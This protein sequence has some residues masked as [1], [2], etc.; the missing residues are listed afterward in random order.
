MT[1]FS[2]A[3]DASE[4]RQQD[5]HVVRHA[6]V[7]EKGQKVRGD[8]QA[9]VEIYHFNNAEEYKATEIVTKLEKEFSRRQF[10]EFEYADVAESECKHNH[11]VGF[12]NCPFKLKGLFMSHSSEISVESL[13]N[14]NEHCHVEDTEV[15]NSKST[16]FKWPEEA[17]KIVKDNIHFK[18]NQILRKLREANVF[19]G[20][21]PSKVQLNNKVSAKKS[22]YASTSVKNTHELSMKVADY[23]K[24]PEKEI[25]A[26][27]PFSDIDDTDISKE[28]RSTVV[29]STKKNLEKLKVNTVLQTD[30]KY[31]LNW[32]RFPVFI[33]GISNLFP[34]FQQGTSSPTGRLFAS[35]AVL[36][37]HEDSEAWS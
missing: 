34:H 22:A 7:N 10:R 28:P 16:N 18:P 4:V 29:F 6:R 5:E 12:K 2:D 15:E 26:F 25:E 11:K 8:A 14:V 23:L 9:W 33:I 30:A 37:S 17:T 19:S 24:E 3:G 32:M 27:V 20:K 35:Y 31:R 13:E 1:A 36:A 21:M